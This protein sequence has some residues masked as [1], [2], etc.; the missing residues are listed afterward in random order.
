MDEIFAAWLSS[1]LSLQLLQLLI[2]L[3][4]LILVGIILPPLILW[5]AP[6]TSKSKCNIKHNNMSRNSNSNS[7]RKVLNMNNVNGG[8]VRL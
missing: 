5:R 4:F 7:S 3:L 6:H 2:V 8:G 1:I